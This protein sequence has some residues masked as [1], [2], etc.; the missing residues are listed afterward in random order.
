M[1]DERIDLL[2]SEY[3]F[4]YGLMISGSIATDEEY[5]DTSAQC[6]LVHD[7][8]L[9]LTGLTREKTHMPSWAHDR[10]WHRRGQ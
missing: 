4:Y 3:L 8:L 9:R 1:M 6:T 7:E 10:L 5:R 2:C